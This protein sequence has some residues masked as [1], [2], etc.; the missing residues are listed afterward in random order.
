MGPFPVILLIIAVQNLTGIAGLKKVVFHD[1]QIIFGHK[2]INIRADPALCNLQSFGNIS[3]ALDQNHLVLKA[4]QGP[5]NPVDLP[6]NFTLAGFGNY[7]GIGQNL[8]CLVRKLHPQPVFHGIM[9]KTPP[10]F[11][12]MRRQKNT[13]PV[14]NAQFKHSG[15]IFKNLY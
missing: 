13:V 5:A 12:H 8:L 11:Q 10:Q 2:N 1:I 15:G 7:S 9:G 3:A 6:H 4:K 14:L